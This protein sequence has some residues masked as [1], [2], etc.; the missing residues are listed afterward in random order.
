MTTKEIWTVD[1]FAT[2]PYR[3][4]P[5]AVVF[6][7]DDLSAADMQKIA[8]EMNLSETVFLLAATVLEA[9]YRARIFTPKAE[10]PFAGH[11]T[12]SAAFAM[13]ETERFTPKAGASVIRQECGAG[14]VPV[15]IRD[16]DMREFVMT[17]VP[18]QFHEPTELLQ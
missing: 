4:N 8:A 10:L 13:T 15:E 7:A 2:T 1:A 11:P 5:C 18:A 12:I 17:Q 9:D 3:G 6:D 14:I 16:T